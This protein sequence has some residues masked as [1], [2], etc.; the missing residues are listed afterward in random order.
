MSRNDA[1]PE[2]EEARI[3]E[4]TRQLQQWELSIEGVRALA[5]QHAEEA[6]QQQRSEL[7]QVRRTLSEAL[8]AQQQQQQ[9]QQ[10][11]RPNQPRGGFQIT[12]FTVGGR[13]YLTQAPPTYCRTHRR[14]QGQRPA[15]TIR[16][17]TVTGVDRITNR[18]NFITDPGFSSWRVPHHLR[19]LTEQEEESTVRLH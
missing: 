1:E 2:N 11:Q 6:A 19:F 5:V 8:G 13:V 17:A 10:Q 9:Q 12:D 7:A 4:L 15:I 3:E 16:A 18:A 14:S